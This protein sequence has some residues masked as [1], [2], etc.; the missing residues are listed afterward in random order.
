MCVIRIYSPPSMT[1]RVYS[2][3]SRFVDTSPRS[4]LGLTAM[5]VEAKADMRVIV[6]FRTAGRR[7]AQ[8]RG[9]PGF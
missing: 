8:K 4:G 3:T 6:E 9:M 1:N 5:R 7:N 2:P